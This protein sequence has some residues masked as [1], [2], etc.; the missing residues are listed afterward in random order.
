MLD[1]RVREYIRE[2]SQIH[3]FTKRTERMVL[4]CVQFFPFKRASIFTYS[5]FSYVGEGLIQADKGK[6]TSMHWIKEDVR[7]IPP[8]YNA[9]K[10]NQLQLIDLTQS[11]VPFPEKYINQFKLSTLA[12]IPISS[13]NN[14]IGCVLADQY[15]GRRQSIRSHV[16]QLSYYFQEFISQNSNRILSKRETEVL[17]HLAN[18][19]CMKEMAVHMKI[20]EFTVRD[21][22]S[23]V[24]RKLGVKHRA[25][26]V[27]VGLRKGIIH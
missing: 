4:G 25:E 23:A 16:E 9:L 27:A 12:I 8:V 5:S 11:N 15:T 20:S 2:A 10:N 13:S 18:G 17:Q 21:Y 1:A 24:I 6:I 3:D 22:L 7:Y 26:A 19:Y 14:V